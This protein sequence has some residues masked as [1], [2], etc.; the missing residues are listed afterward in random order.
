MP[1]L[2]TLLVIVLSLRER[3][4]APKRFHAS[5]VLQS[6]PFPEIEKPTWKNTQFHF[7]LGPH[8]ASLQRLNIVFRMSILLR[9]LSMYETEAL[10]KIHCLIDTT[11][12]ESRVY[13]VHNETLT[14]D[15]NSQSLNI[16]PF[17]LP[18]YYLISLS[19]IYRGCI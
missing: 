11:T 19:P 9:L 2:A 6:L 7:L 8:L 4:F 12:W 10:L 3:D 15:V 5:T 13:I 18:T 16:E 17:Y 14:F 1:D